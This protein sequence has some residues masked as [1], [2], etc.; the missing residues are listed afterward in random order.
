MSSKVITFEAP[1]DTVR[2]FDDA[3]AAAS[4]SR[5]QVLQNLMERY[6]A[7]DKAFRA[8]VQIGL[9]QADEGLLIDHAEIESRL[10][11]WEQAVESSSHAA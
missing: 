6:L 5:E 1:E 2:A 4:M 8:S 7:Y 10:L 11:R 3:A 9:Q